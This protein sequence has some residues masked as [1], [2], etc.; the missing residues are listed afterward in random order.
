MTVKKVA[1]ALAVGVLFLSSLFAMVANESN[2]EAAA[3]AQSAGGLFYSESVSND[4]PFPEPYQTEEGCEVYD[5]V[6]FVKC[7]ILEHVPEIEILLGIEITAETVDAIAGM[8][9]YFAKYV[10]DN[11][12]S[13]LEFPYYGEWLYH[14]LP[15]FHDID[16][17]NFAIIRSATPTN[18]TELTIPGKVTV[19]GKQSDEWN[20]YGI[21]NQ[22]YSAEK[23]N[24]VITKVTMS[25]SVRF[26]GSDI[27]RGQTDLEEIILSKNIMVIGDNCFHST[28]IRELVI[29]ASVAFLDT[30]AMKNCGYLEKIVF[31]GNKGMYLAENALKL[32]SD[33]QIDTWHDVIIESPGNWVGSLPISVFGEMIPDFI[34]FRSTSKTSDAD[35]ALPVAAIIGVVSI[36]AV[37]GYVF[38]IKNN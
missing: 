8:T 33:G 25:D 17:N 15:Y 7:L 16:L 6:S 32:C 23:Y 30:G 14:W 11:P 5:F 18:G 22:A 26:L 35:M 21:Y 34:E 1:V 19:L 20:V 28:G 3:D 24:E 29:P 12:E 10:I 2:G 36:A 13:L 4:I 9:Y 38:L 27:F 31:E 37:A